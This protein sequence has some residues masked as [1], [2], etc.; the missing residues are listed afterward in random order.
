MTAKDLKISLGFTLIELM[1]VISVTA[2]LFAIGVAGYMA[3]NRRQIVTQ[4]SRTIRQDLRLAQSL[5]FN[6]QKPSDCG[7]LEDYTFKLVNQTYKI[8]AN[9]LNPV[10]SYED[11]SPTREVTLPDV[12]TLSGFTQV[13]FKVLSSGVIFTNGPQLTIVGWGL[14]KT[15]TVGEGGEISLQ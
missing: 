13:K 12:L 8:F 11:D 10:H 3:F 14:T 1:V 4:A 2:I 7:T 5:A 15:I 6:N 9:C